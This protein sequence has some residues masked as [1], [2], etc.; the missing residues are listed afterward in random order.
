MDDVIT[1]SCMIE[2]HLDNLFNAFEQLRSANLKLN[3]KKCHFFHQE[4]RY[5]GYV[6]LEKGVA[7]GMDLMKLKAVYSLMVS[8]KEQI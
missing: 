5:L 6:V 8:A 4:V 3:L 7:T 1:V 2:E